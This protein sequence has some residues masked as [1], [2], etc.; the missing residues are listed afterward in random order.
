M[1][2]NLRNKLLSEWRG[3]P[4]YEPPPDRVQDVSTEVEKLLASLGLAGRIEESEILSE[5]KSIVGDFLATHSQ[6]LGL[7]EGCLL[8]RVTQPTVRYE[9]ERTW[10]PKILKS[11]QDRFGKGCVKSLRF[12]F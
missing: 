3:L 7:K 8:V 9:L 2:K 1:N 6:P 4:Q 11:L 5:W 10:K 12:Q